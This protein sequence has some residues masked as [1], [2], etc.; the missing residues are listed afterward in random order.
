MA[1][2]DQAPLE[3]GLEAALEEADEG[4]WIT[5]SEEDQQWVQRSR[6]AFVASD[7]WFNNSIRRDVEMALSNFRSKHP[8]GSRYNTTYYE[9]RSR[10]FRPKTRAMVRRSEAA[11]ALAFFSTADCVACTAYNDADP[12]QRLAAEIHQALLNDRMEDPD[13][14]W[15]LTVIGGVQD[16]L[17]TGVVC[18]RQT[19]EYLSET[20]SGDQ[21][22]SYEVVQLDRPSVDLIPLEN[23]RISPTSDWR[24]PIESSPFVIEMVP[25]YVYEIKE[26]MKR[27]D[28]N[29]E[30]I[31]RT[32]PEGMLYAAVKQDWD[33][34][35]RAREGNRVDKYDTVKN[36]SDYETVWV[37]KNI[38]RRG[39]RDWV[40]DTVGTYLMLSS[41][42]KP[43]EEV[44]HTGRR[45]YAMGFCVIETHKQYP[46]SPVM[47]SSNLQEE[48]NDLANLRIDNIRLALQ[49]RWLV[50][51]GAGVDTNSLMRG[52]ASSV[53]Y[54]AN[55]QTDVKELTTNDV[56]QSSY[57]EQDR[58]N[59]DFDELV[60][61]FSQS[62]VATNRHL[63]QTV[64]GMNML[65]ADASQIQ[66]YQIRTVAE[67]WLEPVLKQL[68]QL[69]S[70]YESDEEILRKVGE[71]LGVS[72][73]EMMAVMRER[74]KVKVN[75]GFN[76][77][78][79]E[80]RIQRLALGLA[81]L[82]QYFPQV[83]QQ[84]DTREIA[85]EIF[86]ALG[87]KDA[88]RFLPML[89][90]QPGEDPRIQQLM[91]QIEQLTQM[92]QTKQL[93]NQ[94]KIDVANINAEAKIAVAKMQGEIEMMKLQSGNDLDLLKTKLKDRLEQVDRQLAIEAQDVR[95]RELYLQREAL[96][97]SIQQADREYALKVAEFGRAGQEMGDEEDGD[98][99]GDEGEGAE[100]LKGT[101]K[102]GTL[103]RG[104]YGSVPQMTDAND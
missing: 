76:A 67:T 26:R 14:A 74:T 64:G 45:P 78:N 58:I 92:L 53:T 35:R 89:K 94:A 86:G 22:K 82:G 6:G 99:G 1:K 47:L 70:V 17:T 75:V 65:S 23:I 73:E 12:K 19:W 97:H 49:K 60:G 10:L 80:K 27:L 77:T 42:V 34:I 20:F 54:A 55:P 21:G 93:E 91:Q 84:G 83:V 41:S 33:S 101:D 103:S 81:T 24:R 104:Q 96:S 88:S 52:I 38:M 16:A 39:G 85:K 43:L 57:A 31:Y 36:V 48:A 87:Y 28:A 9:K 15:F 25:M 5:E 3:D 11:A 32:M 102:A 8:A 51:R 90:Q 66:E 71:Q 50:R 72:V 40:F 69:E 100:D 37:H 30:P 46:S 2:Q 95:R 4:G 44:Y 18:S 59:L 98:E 68:V 7:E 61:A 79:P 62:S 63:N 56:T 13:M 29:G